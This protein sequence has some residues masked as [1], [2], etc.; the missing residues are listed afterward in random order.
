MINVP[1]EDA[2]LSEPLGKLENHAPLRPA[3]PRLSLSGLREQASVLV[4]L[5]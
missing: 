2:V 5:P 3:E 1:W 4:L